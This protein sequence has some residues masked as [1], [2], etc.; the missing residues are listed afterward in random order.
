MHSFKH[1]DT[2]LMF[3]ETGL[4][5]QAREWNKIDRFRLDKFMMVCSKY[6]MSLKNGLSKQNWPGQIVIK[7]IQCIY[8]H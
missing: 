2:A 3:I 7:S 8:I 4:E 1:L 6:V 5:T